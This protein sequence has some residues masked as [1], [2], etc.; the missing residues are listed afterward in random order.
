[1]TLNASNTLGSAIRGE[2]KAIWRNDYKHEKSIHTTLWHHNSKPTLIDNDIPLTKLH[3]LCATVAASSFLFIWNAKNF[4]S[5]LPSFALHKWLRLMMI[6]DE[7]GNTCD[8]KKY[9]S[10]KSWFFATSMKYASFCAIWGY[11][12]IFL[13][14]NDENRRWRVY[15]W[16]NDYLYVKFSIF[17]WEFCKLFQIISGFWHFVAKNA[18]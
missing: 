2:Y 12:L 13:G 10:F 4:L 9:R 18:K 5:R 15:Y 3:F 8:V 1:M 16:L 14:N 6:V 11:L 7:K 17:I